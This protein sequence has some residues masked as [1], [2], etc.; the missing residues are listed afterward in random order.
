MKKRK[1]SVLEDSEMLRLQPLAKRAK[2]EKGHAQDTFTK[3][4]NNENIVPMSH[5]R[6][7]RAQFRLW[8]QKAKNS[9]VAYISG[10]H[11]DILGSSI[12]SYNDQCRQLRAK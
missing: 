3:P 2:I 7:V 1:K 9:E 4:E 11:S 10:T 6:H 5:S 8:S 12:T